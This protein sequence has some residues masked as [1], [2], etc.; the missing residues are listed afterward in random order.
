MGWFG[1]KVL[2]RFPCDDMMPSQLSITAQHLTSATLIAFTL[3]LITALR[4]CSASSLA[5]PRHHAL[6]G[7]CLSSSHRFGMGGSPDSPSPLRL[8]IPSPQSSQLFLP[9]SNLH[10]PLLPTFRYH[11][12]SKFLFL[13]IEK[14]NVCR[15]GHLCKW[16]RYHI[17]LSLVFIDIVHTWSFYENHPFMFTFRD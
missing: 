5:P 17:T 15:G 14:I 2:R 8:P 7:G 10:S 11:P 1:S 12:Q 6:A 9:A 3:V 4:L 13:D 16:E